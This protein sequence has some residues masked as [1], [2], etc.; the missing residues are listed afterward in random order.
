MTF[1]AT[2]QLNDIRIITRYLSHMNWYLECLKLFVKQEGL[3][4]NGRTTNIEMIKPT[5][6]FKRKG[7]MISIHKAFKQPLQ[8]K[9]TQS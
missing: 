2:V 4:I 5:S 9:K 8:Y 1:K 3:C 7:I 6:W